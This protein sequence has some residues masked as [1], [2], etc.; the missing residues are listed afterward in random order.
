LVTTHGISKICRRE[1]RDPWG[2]YWHFTAQSVR[3]IFL[4]YFPENMIKVQVYGNVLTA[5]CYLH[6]LASH[7]LGKSELDF[8]DPDYEVLITVR[9]VKS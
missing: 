4:D 7:E 1:G 5:V 3:K 8:T 2:E 6:G 9:A